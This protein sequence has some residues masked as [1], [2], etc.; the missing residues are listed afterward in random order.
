MSR[1]VFAG[2]QAHMHAAWESQ[3]LVRSTPRPRGHS[4]WV[5][6]LAFGA[7]LLLGLCF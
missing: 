4:A 5:V 3:P 6:L 1:R 2:R 7:G